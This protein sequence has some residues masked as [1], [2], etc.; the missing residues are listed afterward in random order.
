MSISVLYTFVAV[1]YTVN[2]TVPSNSKLSISFLISS[3]LLYNSSIILDISSAEDDGS[4]SSIILAYAEADFVNISFICSS[5]ANVSTYSFAI[6]FISSA[7]NFNVNFVHFLSFPSTSTFVLSD[8]IFLDLSF[9]KSFITSEYLFLISFCVFSSTSTDFMISSIC[10][11]VVDITFLISSISNPF[12]SNK[13]SISLCDI[14]IHFVFSSSDL[15]P[16]CDPS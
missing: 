1:A 13:S 4:A 2:F 16:A 12:S 15:N 11:D 7:S 3:M 6:S 9:M 8:F 5:F 14:V 10:S